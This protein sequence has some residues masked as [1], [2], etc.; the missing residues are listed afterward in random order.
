MNYRIF[1]FPLSYSTSD[2]GLKT[3]KP[4]L[5]KQRWLQ[6]SGLTHTHTLPR[7]QKSQKQADKWALWSTK[8]I[9][10]ALKCSLVSH[11]SWQA[12][13]VSSPA[14]ISGCLCALVHTHE[15]K[16]CACVLQQRERE[17]L[18]FRMQAKTFLHWVQILHCFLQQQWKRSQVLLVNVKTVSIFV[19]GVCGTPKCV[20]VEW[21]GCLEARCHWR[22]LL[23]AFKGCVQENLTTWKDFSGCHTHTRLVQFSYPVRCHWTEWSSL[24]VPV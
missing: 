5:Q 24:L 22:N 1:F 9:V 15:Q 21:T 20:S 18:T 2:P 17:T 13:L 16:G 19:C 3:N 4:N 7:V 12:E 23:L 11:W 14:A 6:W 8:M 10:Q